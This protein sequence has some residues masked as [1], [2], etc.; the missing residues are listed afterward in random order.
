MR[1][2]MFITFL[3]LTGC[4]SRSPENLNSSDL[5]TF[6]EPSP[7]ILSDSYFGKQQDII[8]I[9]KVFTLT[10]EQRAD[11][12]TFINDPGKQNI[13]PNKRVYDYLQ[14][15]LVEFGFYADTL[16]ASESLDS[17]LGN[18]LSL[19]ILSKSLASI[20]EVEIA[21]ELVST[22]PI[23]QKE[24]DVILGSQHVRTLLYEPKRKREHGFLFQ[25]RN[26]IAVDYFSIDDSKFLRRISENEFN[27]MFYNN[28]AAEALINDDVNTAF[29]YSK[30]ALKSN[31]NDSHAINMMAILHEKIG[32]DAQAEK[33]Y[34][35][36]IRYNKI[37]FDLISNYYLLL[38]RLD[39]INEANQIAHLLKQFEQPDPFKWIKQGD[40]KYEEGDYVSAVL[41]YKKAIKIAD[42]LHEPYFGIARVEFL[43]GNL[44]RSRKAM[45]KALNNA[46][47]NNKISLYQTKL[48]LL[49]EMMNK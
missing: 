34:Q 9:D 18:C 20:A 30:G 3:L 16:T 40:K 43:R 5:N 28:K 14:M 49:S 12:L 4:I 46:K 22:P 31:Y 38:Q 35:H 25:W 24:G 13:Y 7:P 41:F 8:S 47:R 17:D 19:A 42:Y 32:Q 26:R 33:I 1:H 27:A 37:N 15:H 45:E 39:K 21:Y 6:A 36:G 29:W 2:F 44:G 10:P 48:Q 23:F 11:F